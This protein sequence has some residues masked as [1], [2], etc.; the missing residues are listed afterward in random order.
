M[1]K[2]VTYELLSK[3][4]L[5][6]TYAAYQT[7]FGVGGFGDNDYQNTTW[8]LSFNQTEDSCLS[9]LPDVPEEG[10]EKV[11]ATLNGNPVV[12]GGR[13]AWSKNCYKY[14]VPSQ[15]WEP[16]AEMSTER[17]GAMVVQLSEEEFWI[18]GNGLEG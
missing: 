18:M 10:S 9:G 12:C 2:P 16:L 8:T 17:A 1:N 13:G 3:Q 15:S 14:N 7:V 11:A 5:F 4:Q 6:C